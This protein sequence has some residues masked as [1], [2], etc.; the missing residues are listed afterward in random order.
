VKLKV[1]E[2]LASILEALAGV[3]ESG[4]NNDGYWVRFADGTQICA[5][6]WIGTVSINTAWG[7]MYESIQIDFG[8]WPKPFIRTPYAFSQSVNVAAQIES[9]NEGTEAK[10]G[11]GYV[12]RPDRTNY[13][14]AFYF[15]G[16]GRWK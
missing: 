2:T 11:K 1:K 3:V 8:N 9:L 14:H 7:S 10:V 13:N 6:S 16:I 15:I 5:H 4:S 12:M